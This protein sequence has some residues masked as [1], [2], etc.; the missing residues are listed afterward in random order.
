MKFSVSGRAVAEKKRQNSIFILPGYC[1]INKNSS[2][3][4]Q[5]NNYE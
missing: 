1:Y 2:Y 5:S 4:D 3:T